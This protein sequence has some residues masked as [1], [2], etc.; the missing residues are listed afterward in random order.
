MSSLMLSRL[1]K[2]RI[3][4]GRI[5]RL[6]SAVSID[7]HMEEAMLHN[8]S[9]A[10]SPQQQEKTYIAEFD[11]ARP[12][13]PFREVTLIIT[14]RKPAEFVLDESVFIHEEPIEEVRLPQPKQWEV[15]IKIVGFRK[16]T[17]VP[18]E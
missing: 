3:R 9:E 1:S 6:S 12:S 16:A 2:E 18:D 14:E 11:F 7:A 15:P 13:L 8:L 5:T 10:T 17:Y 4:Q